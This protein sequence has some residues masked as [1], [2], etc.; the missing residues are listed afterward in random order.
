MLIDAYF[1]KTACIL[2]KIM[3]GND[4]KNINTTLVNIIVHDFQ[5]MGYQDPSKLREYRDY[6]F[7]KNSSKQPEEALQLFQEFL[8]Q[9]STLSTLSQSYLL[10]IATLNV[11]GYIREKAIWRLAEENIEIALPFF[12]IRLEDRVD[13]VSRAARQC[14]RNI[15]WGNDLAF[16]TR[17][18]EQPSTKQFIRKSRSW[19]AKVY[20]YENRYLPAQELQDIIN[21]LVVIENDFNNDVFISGSLRSSIV[22]K[23]SNSLLFFDLVM[24]SKSAKFRNESIA[25]IPISL[26]NPAINYHLTLLKK[27]PPL[28]AG[29]FQ[30]RVENN[31]NIVEQSPSLENLIYHY[32]YQGFT[33]KLLKM[34]KNNSDI[35]I[36][37]IFRE[38][39]K[40]GMVM[41]NVI[42]GLGQYGDE[43]D[44]TTILQFIDH[45]RQKIRIGALEG[46]YRAHYSEWRKIATKL[47]ADNKYNVRKIARYLLNQ[48]SMQF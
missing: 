36:P 11:N 24:Q 13:K 2:E 34:L 23:F 8:Q 31:I 37:T 30:V 10:A 33:V 48:H 22:K 18:F 21:N 43:K 1:E 47:L 46:L 38:A 25:R 44:I 32:I 9:I 5:N 7:S 20:F 17:F 19:D 14:Y 12:L 27:L 40:N 26:I 6:S 39:L 29:Q 16:L 15:I 45:P 35:D 41:P 28:Y 42:R 4:L 3:D